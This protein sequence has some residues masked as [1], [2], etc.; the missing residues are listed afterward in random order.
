MTRKVG[1]LT[2]NRTIC[3]EIGDWAKLQEVID[4]RGFANVS[5]AM[6]YLIK[7]DWTIIQSK[8][9]EYNESTVKQLQ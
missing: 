9:Q 6:K 3:L 8:K 5:A 4:H 2:A 1:T 7:G